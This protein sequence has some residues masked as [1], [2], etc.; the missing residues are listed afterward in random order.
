MG[1]EAESP[2]PGAHRLFSAP[3]GH[4][5][6]PG[7]GP[8]ATNT[9][10]R[11]STA[12]PGQTRRAQDAQLTVSWRWP[13]GVR[14]RGA[15]L[16][17]RERGRPGV[18]GGGLTAPRCSI[19]GAGLPGSRPG[20]GQRSRARPRAA[21]AGPHAGRGPG[22]RRRRCSA[23][24]L[25][26]REPPGR[27][28]VTGHAA[29]GRRPDP[30]AP[31]R[32]GQPV[33]AGHLPA[34]GSKLRPAASA[35]GSLRAAGAP[36]GVS[37]RGAAG[38]PGVARP[39]F[40]A[41]AAPAAFP[42]LSR[43]REPALGHRRASPAVVPWGPKLRPPTLV[44]RPAPPACGGTAAPPAGGGTAAP[45][46]CGGTAPR[47]LRA[48]GPRPARL[49]PLVSPTAEATP[50]TRMR[51]ARRAGRDASAIWWALGGAGFFGL[52]RVSSAI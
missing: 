52:V 2:L 7:T 31:A 33:G 12:G 38:E 45:P 6:V 48:Y 4:L 23:A 34:R 26:A 30:A 14:P 44:V 28:A 24:D 13:P 20:G 51:G 43:S 41:S 15:L 22:A 50:R 3:A 25:T 18:R 27:S 9:A 39:A 37:P 46:A 17:T 47:P 49:A 32:A 1:Q 36:A 35:G 42:G 29:P 5:E 21:G 8:G 19:R 16:G 10:V 40:P 11:K